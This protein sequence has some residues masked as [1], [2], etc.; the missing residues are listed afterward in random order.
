MTEAPRALRKDP[1]IMPA[2]L[3]QNIV[4]D[5]HVLGRSDALVTIVEYGDYQCPHCGRAYHVMKAI[6]GHIGAPLRFVFR[7]FPLSQIHAFAEQAAR[8]AEAAAL[9]GQFWAMHDALFEHQDELQMSDLLGRA[10]DLDL[11]ISRFE[12]DLHSEAVA[13]RIR[14]DVASGL[15]SEVQGTPTFFI[16]GER[17][18]GANDER[19]ILTV[20][21][22]LLRVHHAPHVSR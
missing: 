18:D 20:V 15:Q 16:N 17:H 9:Q 22:N 11:D 8:A 19:T 21:E 3:T 2:R 10:A 1:W 7:N 5:D 12:H 4:G 14:R 13:A 6:R